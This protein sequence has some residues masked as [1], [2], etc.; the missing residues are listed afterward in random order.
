MNIMDILILAFVIL[1]VFGFI[2]SGVV[3]CEKTVERDLRDI[4]GD[5]M[6]EKVFNNKK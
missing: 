3:W 4:Y 5:E 1:V 2:I 6:Y